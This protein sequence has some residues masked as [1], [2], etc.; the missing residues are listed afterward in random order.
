MIRSK[1]KIMTNWHVYIYNVNSIVNMNIY[2]YMTKN[3]PYRILVVV[4]LSVFKLKAMPVS[5]R[6]S[7]RLQAPFLS[8][9][10]I[11]QKELLL[12]GMNH[13]E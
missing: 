5:L 1:A 7:R 6:Q 4:V 2:L 10:I 12:I 9:N 11:D 8:S 13:Y 3:H